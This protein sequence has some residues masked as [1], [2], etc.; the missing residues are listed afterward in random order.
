MSDWKK[1]THTYELKRLIVERSKLEIFCIRTRKTAIIYIHK[2]KAHLFTVIFNTVETKNNDRNE[3][4]KLVNDNNN[5]EFYVQEAYC[6][7]T[8]ER[9]YIF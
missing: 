7:T 6:G 5:L 3:V 8:M 9:T 4:F 2:G 1:I